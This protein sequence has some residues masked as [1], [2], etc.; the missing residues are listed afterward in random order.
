MFSDFQSH[1]FTGLSGNVAWVFR[2]WCSLVFFH[3]SHSV[4]Y[5]LILLLT[6]AWPDRIQLQVVER[7]NHVELQYV[8]QPTTNSHSCKGV[9]S[10]SLKAKNLAGG[11]SEKGLLPR[12]H[13]I[14]TEQPSATIQQLSIHK[15]CG[16]V[17]KTK[18]QPRHRKLL[19]GDES[20]SLFLAIC[21]SIQHGLESP[22]LNCE[23][24]DEWTVSIYCSYC[25]LQIPL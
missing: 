7:K 1:H 23:L 4:R 8:A 9:W 5:W 21:L 11:A 16:F 25:A 17:G 20:I 14:L 19:F 10:W 15:N 13:L 2:F 6:L 24:Y 12:W 18:L 22:P 3:C